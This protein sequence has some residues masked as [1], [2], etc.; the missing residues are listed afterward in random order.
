[1]QA[2]LPVTITER[3][4]ILLTEL[5]SVD[6]FYPRSPLRVVTHIHSDHLLEL[7]SSIRTAHFIV[8]TKLTHELLRALDYRIPAGKELQLPY[9]VPVEYNGVKVKLVASNHVPGSA[10]VVVETETGEVLAY[11]GDFKQPGTPI[12]Q[13]PDVLVIDATYGYEGWVRPWQDRVDEI[14]VD[15]VLDAL[16]YERGV[17]VEAYQGKLQKVMHLLR[18]YG[19]EAPFIAPRRVYQVARVLAS[20]GLK[21][22]DVLLETSREALEAM[23]SGWYI[24]F[25]TTAARRSRQGTTRR[26]IR[27]QLTG[28]ELE[29]P[30]RRISESEWVVSYS[31]HADFNQTLEYVREARPR[32]LIVDAYRGGRVARYFALSVTRRLGI[33]AIALPLPGYETP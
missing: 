14:L 2:Q 12:I 9:N 5:V 22:K 15:V 7:H 33:Q 17:I 32:L 18:E 13:E 8:A 24:Y 4:A 31:D 26:P 11:T 23:R 29:E 25:T 28:W 20:Y 30:F 19:V 10:Q 27:I 1:L 3:G 6:G 16:A 21:T